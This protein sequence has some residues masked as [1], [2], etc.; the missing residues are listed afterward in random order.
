MI[1]QYLIKQ[2]PGCRFTLAGNT[3]DGLEWHEDNPFPKPSE[4]EFLDN[5]DYVPEPPTQEF[6]DAQIAAA[7]KR[8]YI[9]KR[10]AEYPD[11]KEYLDGI[12]KGDQAQIQAYIDACLAV[13][14]KYPK[15][16]GA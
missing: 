8:E 13:K 15:P 14:A 7:A 5:M 12:V 1:A 2:Y 16:E 4:Q 3:Y 9:Q 6:I 10:S 11:F